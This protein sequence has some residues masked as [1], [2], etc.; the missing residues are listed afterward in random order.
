MG[1][2][3]RV[4]ATHYWLANGHGEEWLILWSLFLEQ[5]APDSA[6]RVAYLRR[7]APA[8]IPW[9]DSA[10]GVLHPAWVQGREADRAAAAQRRAALLEQ[11]F[12]ASDVAFTNWLRRQ[13]EMRWPWE[14][15]TPE[16]TARHGTREFWFIS[17]QIA[18]LR[19]AGG[20][21]CPSVP[22]TWR[23]CARALESGDTGPLDPRS[24]LLTLARMLCA[25][26]V[27]APW[28]L[29]LGLADF[30]GSVEND[31]GYVDAFRLWVRSAFDDA[32]QLRLYLEAT[33]PPSEWEAWVA[34]QHAVE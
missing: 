7:H 30:A 20:W 8:P 29:G 2:V 26:Q 4:H 22:K 9:A 18:A 33:R 13:K 10:Y 5:L 12:I 14:R 6:T 28:Q 19:K 3:P 25:G 24:G 23:A 17:R 21:K 16:Q 32:Q 15:G 31:M 27:Q 34:A 11:G 1:A